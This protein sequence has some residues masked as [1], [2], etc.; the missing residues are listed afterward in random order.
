MKTQTTIQ[1]WDWRIVAETTTVVPLWNQM[2]G[3]VWLKEFQR[4]NWCRTPK[5][6]YFKQ[7]QSG[8]FSQPGDSWLGTVVSFKHVWLLRVPDQEEINQMLCSEG[9]SALG[10]VCPRH[11]K[12]TVFFWEVKLT[13]NI[14]INLFI[15]EQVNRVP[16]LGKSLGGKPTPPSSNGKH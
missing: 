11:S 6:H 7:L 8:I 15:N 9:P 14:S 1:L 10:L 12:V 5:A 3:F 2:I 13:E 4:P 16:P